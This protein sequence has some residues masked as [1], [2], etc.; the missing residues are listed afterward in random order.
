[1]QTVNILYPNLEENVGETRFGV[2]HEMLLSHICPAVRR[3]ALGQ[4]NSTRMLLAFTTRP[5]S[6][7][8]LS[9]VS[10]K[11]QSE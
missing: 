9:H 1:M 2:L 3:R 8:S 5:H 4:I 7:A 10:K 11:M 6:W